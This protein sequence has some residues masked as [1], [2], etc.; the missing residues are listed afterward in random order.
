MAPFL[1]AW[2][3]L[4]HTGTSVAEKLPAEGGEQDRVDVGAEIAV[5]LHD[6]AP[7]P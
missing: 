3:V 5:S 4:T 7:L 1:E 6:G 2:S